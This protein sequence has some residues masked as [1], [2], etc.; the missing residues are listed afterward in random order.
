MSKGKHTHVIATVGF[1]VILGLV[2]FFGMKTMNKDESKGENSDVMAVETAAGEG[3]TKKGENAP[4]EQEMAKSELKSTPSSPAENAPAGFVVE[5]GNPVVAKVDGKEITRTDVYRFIRTMPANIQQ[6]PATSVYPMAMEQVINTRIVQNKAEDAKLEETDAFK[7]ELEIAKQQIARNLYLQEQV[8]KKVDEAKI[9]KMY[10]EYLKEIP[11]VEERR[12]RHIL[13]ETEEKAKAVVEK[14]KTGE[15]FEDLA[16]SLSIGPTS[17]K[18]GDLGYF[19]KQEMVPEFA[20][21]A[22]GME[23]GATLETPVQTQFGWHVIQLV[24]VRDRPK[25]SLEQLAPALQAE[26]RRS[27]LDDLLQK[28]RKDAKIE[29]FDINGKPLKKGADATGLTD[30]DKKKMMPSDVQPAA[31]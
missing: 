10:K 16:K 7:A 11:D 4:A 9:K 24:D 15:K 30:A 3:E 18:G 14:L 12:A 17:V 5:E 13:V 27:V 31:Q 22:F 6:M 2:G 8:D 1:V 28:W 26:A 20:K 29:Q 21:A 23:K 19:T 25:P